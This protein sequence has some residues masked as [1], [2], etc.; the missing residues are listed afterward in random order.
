MCAASRLKVGELECVLL[1]VMEGLKK[2]KKR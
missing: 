1:P 2:I